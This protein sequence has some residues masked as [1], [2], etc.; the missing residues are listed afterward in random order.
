MGC[1]YQQKNDRI[2]LSK[3][4]IVKAY[5]LWSSILQTT[6]SWFTGKR[7]AHTIKLHMDLRST[8]TKIITFIDKYRQTL[9]TKENAYILSFSTNTSNFSGLIKIHKN[10]IIID[11]FF[12]VMIIKNEDCITNVNNKITDAKQ[13]LM[14]DTSQTH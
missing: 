14:F 5:W 3:K 12:E 6:V 7:C 2:L 4:R 10:P 13:Y 8:H 11:H 1:H 9:T